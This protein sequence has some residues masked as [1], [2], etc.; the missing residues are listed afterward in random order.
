[1]VDAKTS[2]NQEQVVQI[3]KAHVQ[4]QKEAIKTLEIK[5]MHNLTIVN[6]IAGIVAALNLPF[7]AGEAR[8]QQI[9]GNHAL[10]FF[11]ATVI[12][13]FLIALCALVAILSI[14]ILFFNKPRRSCD[15]KAYYFV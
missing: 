5:A 13:I 3:L 8:L 6:I 4:S 9:L 1:M 7:G 14:R 12:S 15:E 2:H 10:F 11:A